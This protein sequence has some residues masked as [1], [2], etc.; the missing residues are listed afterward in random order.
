[1]KYFEVG[2]VGNWERERVVSYR[3]LSFVGLGNGRSGNKGGPCGCAFFFDKCG[4][5]FDFINFWVNKDNLLKKR[6]WTR[7]TS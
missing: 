3:D 6:R 1:M 7:R 2:G 5:A 4:C